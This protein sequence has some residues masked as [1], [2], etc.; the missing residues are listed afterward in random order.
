MGK[1]PMACAMLT[2]VLPV[3]TI[4][5]VESKP[6]SPIS[7]SW[8][9]KRGIALEIAAFVK[10]PTCH[11]LMSW[12]M[13]MPSLTPLSGTYELATPPRAVLLLRSWRG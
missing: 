12:E 9:L 3:P 8:L 7:R 13:R 10:L 6:S 4:R 5:P 11:Y 2:Y 1:R